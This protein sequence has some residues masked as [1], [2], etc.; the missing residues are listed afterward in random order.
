MITQKQSD[1]ITIKLKHE[2]VTI[3]QLARELGFHRTIV[4]QVI[5]RKLVR[6]DV[7]NALI[8][9]LGSK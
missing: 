8:Q 9:W 1:E 2:S 3:T 5:N 6:Q 4:S 7:E